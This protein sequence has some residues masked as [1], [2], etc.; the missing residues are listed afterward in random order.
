MRL[1]HA[2]TVSAGA[3]LLGASLFGGLAHAQEARAFRMMT[4]EPRFMDPNLASDFSIFVN[5]QLFEPLARIDDKG[6]LV[7]KQAKSIELEPDGKTWTITL[8]PDYKWSNGD[9]IT[10]EDWVY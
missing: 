9:P 8:N 1:P 2:L 10:A 7:L 4:G 3:L 5:A 6:N